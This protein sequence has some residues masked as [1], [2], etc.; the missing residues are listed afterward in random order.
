MDNDSNNAFK[1]TW[2]HMQEPQLSVHSADWSASTPA[3]E[4][5]AGLKG[6]QSG[7]PAAC[8]WEAAVYVCL[9]TVWSAYAAWKSA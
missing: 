5:A 4:S 3:V 2:L 7:T 1:D 6:L 9:D 8:T